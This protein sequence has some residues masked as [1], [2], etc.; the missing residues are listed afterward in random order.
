MSKALFDP[1]ILA[2]QELIAKGKNQKNKGE[3]FFKN[4]GRAV[5]F[6]LEGLCRVY[7]EITNK[8][9]FDTWYKQ[10][11]LIEDML[12]DMD[13]QLAMHEHFSSVAG[14]KKASEKTFL[15]VYTKYST[16]TSEAMLAGGL[17]N[18]TALKE[19]EEG[20]LLTEWPEGDK[21]KV[22]YGLVMCSELEKAEDKYRDGEID[23]WHL[24]NGVHEIRRRLR[25]VSIYAQTA[26]GM[27]QL[28]KSPFIPEELEDYCTDEILTLPFNV[29]PKK[30]TGVQP[31]FVQSNYFYA[32]SWMIQYLGDLKDEGLILESFDLLKKENKIAEKDLKAA[33]ELLPEAT[34]A[35]LSYEAERALDKFFYD[36]YL[37]DRIIRDIIR[38]TH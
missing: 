31:L 7:R 17:L 18:G 35:E 19:F 1:H 25:W 3:S 22:E 24:E 38:S 33:K 30:L 6:R 27:I 16:M 8:K 20:L 10:F 32:L 14:L 36:D 28:R 12:G 26:M 29:M 34:V 23:P 15:S 5:L 11:K 9:F 4:G 2:L 13:H 37:G 21:N